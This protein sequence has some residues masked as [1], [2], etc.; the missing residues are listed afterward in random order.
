MSAGVRFDCKRFVTWPDF[1]LVGVDSSSDPAAEGYADASAE[2]SGSSSMEARMLVRLSVWLRL[3]DSCGGL[4]DMVC[5][6][7]IEE[8]TVPLAGIG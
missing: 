4:S 8:V 7:N 1:F 6:E 5:S 3:G 2:L